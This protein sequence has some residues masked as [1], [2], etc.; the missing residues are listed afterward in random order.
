M[1][2]EIEEGNGGRA[3]GSDWEQEQLTEARGGNKNNPPRFHQ[4]KSRPINSLTGR[5]TRKQ[6]TPARPDLRSTGPREA[7]GSSGERKRWTSSRRAAVGPPCACVRAR[8]VRTEVGEKGKGDSMLQSFFCLVDG[9]DERGAVGEW[10]LWSIFRARSLAALACFPF[11]P[12]K[13]QM[14]TAQRR[15]GRGE[16]G[17]VSRS[18]SSR[19]W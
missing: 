5:T 15:R 18:S 1:G 14:A 4:G 7:G 19:C 8:A 16:G 3:F 10:Y 9:L 17:R 2:R 11:P 12:K 6:P 13:S